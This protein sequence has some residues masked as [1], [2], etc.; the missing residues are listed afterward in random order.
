M[1]T[2]AVT[3]RS[4]LQGVRFFLPMLRS[5][6]RIRKQLALAPGCVRFAS[7]IMGPREFWTLTI[8]ESRQKML[9]FMRSGEHED[10]M[11]EFSHWLD[12]FWLMR[13]RPTE[14]ESGKWSGLSLAQRKA[15]PAPAPERTR[16]QDAALQAAWK[17]LPR[18]KAAS[19]PSGAPSLDY[20]PGQRRARQL[21]AGGVGASIRIEVPALRETVAGWNAL[22]LLRT[23]L[24]NNEDVLRCAFG[25]SK[26]RELYAL[27][28]FRH[29]RTWR[30]FQSSDLVQ[31][32]RQR[33]PEGLWTMRW[34]ADNEFGHWD[35]LRLR[36]VKLGTKVT[37]P[38]AF[39]K[40][41]RLKGDPA[42]RSRAPEGAETAPAAA[43]EPAADA[44]AEAGA[45][46][47][48]PPA[49][50]AAV[51][52]E[53]DGTRPREA[54]PEKADVAAAAAAEPAPKPPPAA[55]D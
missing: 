23:S 4:H 9:D 51:E 15:L 28:I 11:W 22:R 8:W 14:E 1:I 44:K 21:V 30:D 19:A 24:L 20:A 13:W 52:Q 16:E 47:G 38:D 55:G 18:L 45:T 36:R 46:A 5:S 26:P 34:E 33:W 12:S 25:V 32:M 39:K 48:S 41:I 17:T 6:L 37:Y 31:A 10:I 50:A 27:I 54:E 42:L 40:M 29:D 49:A 35:G 53:A 43:G 7:I 3:T 2:L